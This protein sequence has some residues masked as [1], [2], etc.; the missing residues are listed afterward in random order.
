MSARKPPR[1]ARSRPDASDRGN[2]G[3]RRDDIDEI[4]SDGDW[5]AAFVMAVLRTGLMLHDLLCDLLE[6]LPEDAFQGEDSGVVLVEML[7]GTIRPAA[8]AAGEQVV[9]DATALLYASADRTI[10]DL[11]AALVLRRAMDR[12]ARG[13]G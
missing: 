8:N 13:Q 6:D 11:K 5:T 10:E 7:T 1:P 9:R 4:E 2:A 3:R 12:G